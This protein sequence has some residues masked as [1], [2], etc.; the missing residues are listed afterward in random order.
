VKTRN[1][2][3]CILM[4]LFL[5]GD[6]LNAEEK[7]LKSL[8][9]LDEGD[10]NKYSRPTPK[11]EAEPVL[12]QKIKEGEAIPLDTN[13]LKFFS[14]FK[15]IKK[16]I[17]RVRSYPEAAREY[18][19]RGSSS[20]QFT[21]LK[22]GEVQDVKIVKS[23]GHNILDQNAIE[24]IKKAAPFNPFPKRIEMSKISVVTELEYYPNLTAPEENQDFPVGLAIPLKNLKNLKE[25]APLPEN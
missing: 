2:L 3:L 21:L 12:N 18:F 8:P 25:V 24:T 9:L 14:Y 16:Q 1:I 22:N 4:M 11:K 7:N 5:S 6:L 10:L 20:V 15:T 19:L 23:S 17:S 13:N